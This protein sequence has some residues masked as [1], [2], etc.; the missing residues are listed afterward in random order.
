MRCKRR[1]SV[2]SLPSFFLSSFRPFSVILIKLGFLS[3]GWGSFLTTIDT[4]SKSR[5]TKSAYVVRVN[6]D[7]FQPTVVCLW[8]CSLGRRKLLAEQIR[9]NDASRPREGEKAF[10]PLQYR[11]VY[12]WDIYMAGD[13]EAIM[14]KDFS[15]SSRGIRNSMDAANFLLFPDWDHSWK[16]CRR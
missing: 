11:I 9:V 16:V 8:L 6:E 7:L 5:Y 10:Q 3:L 1:R 14:P 13:F 12:I 2:V 15:S 4:R